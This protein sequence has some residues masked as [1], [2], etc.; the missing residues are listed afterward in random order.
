MA[1]EKFRGAR[2]LARKT[3]AKAA[4]RMLGTEISRKELR[5]LFSTLYD[6]VNGVIGRYR[7]E[8]AIERFLTA[9]EVL[10]PGAKARALT[11][12]IKNGLELEYPDMFKREERS[13]LRKE[14]ENVVEEKI[15]EVSRNG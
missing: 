2:D 7:L 12:R 10:D 11:D 13:A 3:F 4:S 14:I 8:A 6:Y 5:P 1:V 15:G 9:F